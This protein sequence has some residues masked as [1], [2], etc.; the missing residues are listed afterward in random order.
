PSLYI[1]WFR[2]LQTLDNDL[3]TFQLVRSSHQHCPNA[4]VLPAD[5]LLW[6]C[7]LI[8]CF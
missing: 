8:P 4:A 3:Q 5:V 2:P 6:P 7:H 1:H